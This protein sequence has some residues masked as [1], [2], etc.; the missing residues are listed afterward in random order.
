MFNYLATVDYDEETDC[1]EISFPDFPDIQ[2]VAYSEENIEM[3]AAE[4]LIE[5]LNSFIASRTLIPIPSLLEKEAIKVHLPILSCLK[6]ALH[7]AIIHTNT[8]K[9]DLARKLNLNLQQIDRLLDIEHASKVD[10]LEQAL[11][12]LGYDV[13]LTVSYNKSI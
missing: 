12:L 5:G 13:N 11:Y 6:I 8:R 10:T 1:Y 7:N 9:V 2:G 4:T 3:E